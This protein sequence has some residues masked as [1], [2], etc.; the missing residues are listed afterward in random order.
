MSLSLKIYYYK[1]NSG[2]LVRC[3]SHLT[4]KGFRFKI[5]K[6]YKDAVHTPQAPSTTILRA[7]Q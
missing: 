4:L 3:I 5:T 7:I 1:N 2:L 6:T